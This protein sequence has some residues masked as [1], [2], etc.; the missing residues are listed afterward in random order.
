MLFIKECFGLYELKKSG[1]S[2]SKK[3]RAIKIPILI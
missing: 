2:W 3:N 1:L